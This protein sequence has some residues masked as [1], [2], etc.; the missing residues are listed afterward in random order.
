MKNNMTED[1]IEE[2][3]KIYLKEVDKKQDKYIMTRKE[4]INFCLKM[5]RLV[6]RYEDE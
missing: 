1:V 3:T 2:L 6:R 5:M 4:L